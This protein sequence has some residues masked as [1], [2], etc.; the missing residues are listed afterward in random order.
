MKTLYYYYYL[1]QR[2]ILKDFKDTHLM[3]TLTFGFSVSI[4][5][6]FG[7]SFIAAYKYCFLITNK[8][9]MIA[10]SVFIVAITSLILHANGRAKRIVISKPKFFNS[11]SISVIATLLFFIITTSFFFW[12][13]DV[14]F[15]I[16]EKC[17]NK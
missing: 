16:M 13:A 11:N 9:L 7:V 5:F 1:Y 2:A 14:L 17:G 12:G 3:A 15:I 10:M 8:F 6:V 4:P